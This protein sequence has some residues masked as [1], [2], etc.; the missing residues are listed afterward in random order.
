MTA[1]SRLILAGLMVFGGAG[2]VVT[3]SVRYQSSQA[4]WR[5]GRTLGRQ[6]VTDHYEIYTTLT[7]DNLLRTFPELMERTYEYYAHLVPPG[8]ALEHRMPIYLFATRP[9][10]TLFTQRFTGPRAPIFL[11]IRNGGYSERGVTVIQYVSHPTTFPLMAHEGLHQY[12]FHQVN[13]QVPAWLNE[14]LAT[15]CEG[16]RWSGGGLER[17]EPQY[18]PSRQNILAEAV[19]RNELIPLAE[20]LATNAG[21]IVG[22]PGRTVATYYA[23]LW[24]LLVFLMEGRDGQ[25]ADK[26]RELS[27]SLSDP[28][29][30]ATSLSPDA[31][32]SLFRRYIS[33]DLRSFEAE[34]LDFWRRRL[35]GGP[36]SPAAQPLRRAAK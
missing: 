2:C 10:W 34:Y 28:Q 16:Q 14:G 25:Y 8:R 21:R 15:I 13:P 32:Q 33:D 30:V 3:Q 36:G 23:Q 27:E 20:L 11:Q 29:I 12:L 35:L 31:G 26:L 17:F 6:I 22:G 18:N 1:A 7:D 19:L 24:A 4:E 5:F 9:E